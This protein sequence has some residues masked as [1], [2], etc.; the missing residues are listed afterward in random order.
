MTE[1]TEK[2]FPSVNPQ[3]NFRIFRKW[4]LT[5]RKKNDHIVLLCKISSL[6]LEGKRFGLEVHGF[7]R[8]FEFA[9]LFSS[10]TAHGRIARQIDR[11]NVHQ[12]WNPNSSCFIRE[13]TLKWIS[14]FRKILMLHEVYMNSCKNRAPPSR[15]YFIFPPARNHLYLLTLF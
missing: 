5:A 9:A 10:A 14:F 15:S 3:R 4:L 12:I 1:S 7:L 6:I 13:M 11:T 8:Q 2:I